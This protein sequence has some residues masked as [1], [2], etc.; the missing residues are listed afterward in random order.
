MLNATKVGNLATCWLLGYSPAYR[1][2]QAGSNTCSEYDQASLIMEL[3]AI[4][5]SILVGT[6]VL[7]IK[8]E[9]SPNE[10]RVPP[11]WLGYIMDLS[12][13]IASSAAG[14]K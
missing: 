3:F 13:G 5:R 12:F 8:I 9:L 11:V 7:S 2:L 1:I 4:L 10:L 14:L 6:T